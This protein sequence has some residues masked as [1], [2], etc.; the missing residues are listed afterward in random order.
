MTELE[1]TLLEALKAKWLA[2]ADDLRGTTDY[3]RNYLAQRQV[4]CL[5]QCAAELQAAIAEAPQAQPVEGKFGAHSIGPFDIDP[6]QKRI[7]LT[8]GTYV[9]SQPITFGI[10]GDT[11]VTGV[12][13]DGRP[14]I[15]V[16]ES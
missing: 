5:C 9:L 6:A 10:L 3:G 13:Y 14:L 8:P 4:A 2:F 7:T 15:V 1:R 16:H 11:V 12:E